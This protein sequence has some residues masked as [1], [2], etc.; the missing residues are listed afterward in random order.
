MRTVAIRGGHAG[1]GASRKRR[2]GYVNYL[3][4]KDVQAIAAPE[5]Q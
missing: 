4:D 2:S 3:I 5:Q 1:L